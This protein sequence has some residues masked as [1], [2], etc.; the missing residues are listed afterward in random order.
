MH[1]RINRFNELQIQELT[2]APCKRMGASLPEIDP[3]GNLAKQ[4]C[5]AWVGLCPVLKNLQSV[6]NHFQKYSGIDFLDR[7]TP[8]NSSFRPAFAVSL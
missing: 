3:F 2:G 4:A 8:R 7:R 1:Y 6:T 5:S